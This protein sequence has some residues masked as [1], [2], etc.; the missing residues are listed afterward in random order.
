MIQIKRQLKDFAQSG[1]ELFWQRQATLAGATLLAAYYINIRSALICYAL[2]QICEFLDYSVARRVL[3]WDGKNRGDAVQ[4]L[5]KLSITSAL[6]ASSIVLYI[7]LMALAEGPSLHTGPLFFL[8][9][10]ALYSAMNTCQIPRILII[11]LCVFSAAFVFI[12]VYDI[13]VVRPPL[14]S[15]LWKQLGIVLFVLYFLI[16]CSR[17]FLENYM[18]RLKH[19]RELRIERDRV[20]DAYKVQ[21]QFIA[22]V[23]H[24][25][26]TPLTSVKA[27]LDLLNNEKLGRLPGELKSI[28]KLGQAGGNRLAVLI[29]DLLYFQALKS[30]EVSL[31]LSQIEL[32]QFVRTAV[33]E[34]SAL[35]DDRDVSV[36][37][38]TADTAVIVE[39][40]ARRLMQVMSNVL[41]N[42]IKFSSDG[43]VVDV[44]IET[45]ET[46]AKVLIRDSGI[47]IPENSK[48]IVFAP[49]QQVACPDKRDHGGTGLG[50]SISKKILE[51]HG[52]TIDYTSK[53]GV[54][55][56][57]TIE[58]NRLAVNTTTQPLIPNKSMSHAAE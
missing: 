30:G 56:T 2:C 44:R 12:P 42:A 38:D 55:T 5:H 6:C 36:R 46:K 28:A 50:M 26:R 57:F 10:A 49:F 43:G 14:D 31:D 41:S 24:E 51:A 20:T 34:H 33:A 37:A 11:R 47:G 22:I 53:V 16:E 35:G 15:D 54:G 7:V 32:G 25:L 18:T 8:F 23:S 1:L 9:A 13:W 21:S 58:L 3:K 39:G 45:S 29:N 40:D 4:Y 52:G 17:K 27:S 19:L 48:T